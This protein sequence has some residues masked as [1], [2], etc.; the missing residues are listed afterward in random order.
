ML[1]VLIPLSGK[2][3]FKINEGNSFP[4]ILNE[5]NGKLLIERA[6]E[7]FVNLSLDKK[8]HGCF[9]SGRG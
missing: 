5:V 2:N 4:R 8:N 6:A 3:T 1:N 9:S 7:P